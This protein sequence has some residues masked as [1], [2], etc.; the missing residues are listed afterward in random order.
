[1]VSQTDLYIELIFKISLYAL[2]LYGISRNLKG[3]ENDRKV[4]YIF[5]LVLFAG[6]AY[7]LRKWEH[8]DDWKNGKEISNIHSMTIAVSFIFL[9]AIMYYVL[10]MI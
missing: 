8:V 6:F 1:M 9:M 10:K 3:Y 4:K 5:V 7:I 2:I